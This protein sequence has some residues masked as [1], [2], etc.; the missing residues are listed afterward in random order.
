MLLNSVALCDALMHR[1]LAF[2]SS[3]NNSSNLLLLFDV[4]GTSS[5]GGG[6]LEFGPKLGE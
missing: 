3:L 4:V 5:R 2:K 6:A 1:L